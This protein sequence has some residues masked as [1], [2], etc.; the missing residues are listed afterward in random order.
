MSENY[1]DF[2]K[3]VFNGVCENYK[4]F[5]NEKIFPF[6]PK[7]KGDPYSFSERNLTFNFCQTY[8]FLSQCNNGKDIFVF[9]ELDVKYFCTGTR[10][11]VDSLIYDK[12]K[13]CTHFHR[14]QESSPRFGETSR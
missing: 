3:Q 6:I 8:L 12:K 10:G 5:F 7:D 13:K 2:I 4:N 9:Q 14:S 11:H 1:S